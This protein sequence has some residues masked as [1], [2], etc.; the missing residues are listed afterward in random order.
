MWVNHSG[1]K[2]YARIRDVLPLPGLIEVQLNS[3]KWFQEKGLRELFDE[4]SP[5]QSFNKTLELHFLDYEFGKPKYTVE[6]CRLRDLTYAAPL[7]VKVRLVNH[8]TGEIQEQR[9]FFGDFPLMTERGTFIVNGAERVVV[10]Q[11][12]RSPGV[13]F[14]LE[15]DRAT[16]RQ[17]CYAKLIPN[18]GAW[19]EFETSKRDV[20][21]VKVERRRKMPVTILLRAVGYGTDEELIELFEAVD[22]MPDHPYIKATI[23]KDPS[24]S[25]EEALIEFY[26]R[27]RPGDPPTVENARN[28]L[29]ALFFNP[30]RYDLSRVGRYKLNK[31]LGLEIPID[32]RTLTKEDLVKVVEKMI[33]IN[34]G[35]EA[36]DDIDHLGNRRVRTVG[37]LIQN[38]M[39]V[40][41]LRL[42]RVVKERMSIREPEEIT[43][44]SLIN[45][46]PVMAALR[47]F[48]GGSQ[49]SQFM[50]QTNPLAE[51]THKRRVSAL[52]P[53]GLRR[54]RAGFEVRDVH[55]SH[56]GRICPIET[57]EGPNIGLIGSL[58]TYARINPFGFLET[59]YRKVIKVV[60]NRPK[61]LVGKKLRERLVDPETGEVVAEAG[62]EI[63]EELA[64]RIAGL[65][66][67][68]IKIWPMVTDEV[69]YL[70]ADEEEQFT[71]AQAN[72]PVDER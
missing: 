51:L 22:T 34:N 17:L 20:I 1:K 23:E 41:L 65:P 38:Q 21:A 55:H 32:H 45:I 12:I 6:E 66:Y 40:G 26:R 33:M 36:E 68:E 44:I 28:Y 52:G 53:G 64:E 10:S 30:R 67:R 61:E 60:P 59:P 27:M 2:N 57:P 70:T 71:I 50:D 11:L 35:V 63:T 29:T 19:L 49:L 69:V 25:T 14:T 56:Y 37:E 5:I 7:W 24:R 4:I 8:E 42:E 3:Y 15:E 48:F 43:P 46:R 47:E 18:R 31:R 9:I 16:G 39:R 13:Y 54:E 58:A 62:T 72:A